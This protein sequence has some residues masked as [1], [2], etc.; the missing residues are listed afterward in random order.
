MKSLKTLRHTANQRITAIDTLTRIGDLARDNM[1]SLMKGTISEESVCL[2]GG[3]LGNIA[4]WTFDLEA[5][6]FY[7]YPGSN[8]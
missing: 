3:D 4:G 7:I 1:H 5:G 2:R 8:Q 6:C